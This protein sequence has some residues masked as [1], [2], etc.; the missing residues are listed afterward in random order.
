MINFFI[1][2]LGIKGVLCV[3]GHVCKMAVVGDLRN[4]VISLCRKVRTGSSL[5][6]VSLKRM[7]RDT[8]SRRWF[9]GKGLRGRPY[10][11]SHKVGVFK[12]EIS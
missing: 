6:E 4:S 1:E 3:G 12:D 8:R 5:R 9:A 2:L 7:E 10:S 11:S